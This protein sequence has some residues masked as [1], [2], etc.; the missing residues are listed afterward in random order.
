VA[1]ENCEE[2]ERLLKEKTLVVAD[3]QNSLSEEIKRI[4]RRWD[5][6]KNEKTNLISEG[7]RLETLENELENKSQFLNEKE[8]WF[9]K[10]QWF[11][12]IFN[13]KSLIKI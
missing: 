12:I 13:I 10:I 1:N 3:L 7:K 9:E 6:L 4:E 2:R 5:Q 11:M 8:T